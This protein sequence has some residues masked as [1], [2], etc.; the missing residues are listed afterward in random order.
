MSRRTSSSTVWKLMPMSPRRRCSVRGLDQLARHILK[1]RPPSP[2]QALQHGP[3]LTAHIVIA[4]AI[5]ELGVERRREDAE[6]IGVVRDER[7]IEIGRAK[8]QRARRRLEPHRA[9]KVRFIPGASWGARLN[10]TRVGRTAPT[11]PRCARLTIQAKHMSV[12]TD[13]SR[14]CASSQW[15]RIAL[16]PPC[17]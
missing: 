4:I 9:A 15:N 14:S 11:V 1:I 2:Q 5:G 10:S 16:S 7:T 12:S 17:R 8:N 3:H 6:Q 13:D